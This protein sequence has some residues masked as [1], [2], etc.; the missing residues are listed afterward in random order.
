MIYRSIID[1]LIKKITKKD[2]LPQDNSEI[3]LK[4]ENFLR[5]IYYQYNRLSI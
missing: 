4:L 3:I 1:F 2:I 5:F